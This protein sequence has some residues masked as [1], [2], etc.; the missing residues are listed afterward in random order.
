MRQQAF[1]ALLL[2]RHSPRSLSPA[3]SKVAVRSATVKRANGN[4]PIRDEAVSDPGCVKTF[5][6]V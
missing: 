5:R 3:K 4:W 1:Q 6:V 2:T